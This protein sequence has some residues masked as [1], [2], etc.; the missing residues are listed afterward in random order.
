MQD[1]AYLFRIGLPHWL[2][3]M[4]FGYRIGPIIIVFGYRIG[5]IIILAYLAIVLGLSL[6]YRIGLIF[7]V[8]GFPHRRISRRRLLCF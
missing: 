7:I 3:T 5:L 1:W 8:L 6:S 2:I 4:V